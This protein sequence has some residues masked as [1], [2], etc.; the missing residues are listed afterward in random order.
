[1]KQYVMLAMALVMV[2]SR[3][4]AQNG[5]FSPSPV[6]DRII[7]TL[8]ATPASSQAV[9][10]RTDT[11]VTQAQAQF[12][13]ATGS[14]DFRKSV[15]TIWATSSF[16]E[17]IPHLEDHVVAKQH[18]LVFTDLKPDTKYA[19]RV[20]DG[21]HWSEWFHFTT[22]RADAGPVS[23]L[24]FGDSQ[25]ELKSMWSRVVREAYGTMP[26]V[27]FMLHAGDLINR[28]NRD[29]EWGEWYHAAGWINGSVP[30]VMTP[31]NHEYYDSVAGDRLDRHKKL[32][33]Y[34]QQSFR[35]PENGPAG[36]PELRET[37]YFIDYHDMRLISLNSCA[38]RY[39]PETMEVQRQWLEKVLKNNPK[40]W[41]VVT[42]HFPLYSARKGPENLKLRTALQP[43]YEQ[44]GVDLVLQG[45]DHTYGRGTNKDYGAQYKGDKGPVYVVSVSGPKMYDSSFYP[46]V[47]RSA[48]NTQLY[49]LIK[50]E[51][52]T[53]RYE[54][55]TA[56][57]D[58]YDAFELQ[59]DYR[60]RNTFSEQAPQGVKEAVDLPLKRTKD[61]TDAD[62][63]DYE[64]RF[65]AYKKRKQGKTK[66]D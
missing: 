58:L 28:S 37:V 32:S 66:G 24:Y 27:D 35:L 21:S 55:Y 39:H 6:P 20:G 51:D 22:A 62:F 65:K 18:E 15:K 47:D 29:S 50:I 9:S 57:G 4:C 17:N 12:A 40:K 46:W 31:G 49:Q 34:W 1:M 3:V 16:F 60:G 41:T 56:I 53:L 13:Q 8:T 7:L 14:P 10:W 42:H 43:L 5:E 19:Y 2:S 59:K 30:S 52:N 64:K 25:T 23:F 54:A 45:H 38:A 61:W 63:D 11:S 36:I 48:S 44:Y 33:P 26:Q